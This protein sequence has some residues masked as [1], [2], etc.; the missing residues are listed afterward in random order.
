M[1]EKS[2]KK[3][4]IGGCRT[5]N[6]NIYQGLEFR[7]IIIAD[8]QSM[9]FAFVN[10]RHI[11]RLLVNNA[12]YKVYSVRQPVNRRHFFN[13]FKKKPETKEP[14]P[15]LTEDNLLHPFSQSPFPDIRARGEAIRKLAPCPVCATSHQEIPR[16]VK[17][18]CPDCGWPTH[19]TGEHWEA[20]EE[21]SKYCS[22]LREVNEDDHDLRSGRR[23]REF[24]MPGMLSLHISHL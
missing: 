10:S 23:M 9:A 21:H 1:D 5:T 20:D 15:I 8:R 13:F 18:E 2:L 14:T 22:R 16:A 3:K 7:D 4:F 12:R 19:C 11:T 17:F 24:E 6:T